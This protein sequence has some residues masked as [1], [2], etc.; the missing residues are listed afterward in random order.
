M[1]R[2][3]KALLT[4]RLSVKPQNPSSSRAPFFQAVTPPPHPPFLPCCH[5]LGLHLSD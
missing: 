1:M 5:S 3:A 2:R 4:I